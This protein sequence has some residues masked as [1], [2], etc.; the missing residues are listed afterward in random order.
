MSKSYLISYDLNKKDKD[1]SS[2]YEAIKES[3]NGVWAHILDSTWLIKSNLVITDIYKNIK[4]V[5]DDNDCFFIVEITNNYYGFL[6][7]DIWPYLE[8]NIFN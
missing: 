4:N 6:N 3:S 2:L 8:K 1:Y 7:K 5:T